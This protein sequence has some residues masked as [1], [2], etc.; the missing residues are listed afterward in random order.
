MGANNMFLGHKTLGVKGSA[1]H[2]ETNVS[3]RYDFF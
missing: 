3:I 2:S 1:W